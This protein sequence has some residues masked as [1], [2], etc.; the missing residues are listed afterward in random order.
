MVFHNALHKNEELF[1]ER[2]QNFILLRLLIQ[3]FLI[4]IRKQR[5]QHRNKLLEDQDGVGIASIFGNELGDNVS[6]VPVGLCWQVLEI[7]EQC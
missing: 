5:V 2:L 6:L 3:D 7:D 4:P 1:K